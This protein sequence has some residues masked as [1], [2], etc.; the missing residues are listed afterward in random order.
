MKKLLSAFVIIISFLSCS[1]NSDSSQPLYTG[2]S[3]IK[4]NAGGTLFK[5]E[6]N[7]DSVNAGGHGVYAD[8]VTKRPNV[9]INRYRIY[10]NGGAG[11]YVFFTI[12]AEDSLRAGDYELYN[13]LTGAEFPKIIIDNKIYEGFN[14]DGSS[15]ITLHVSR[16]SNGSMDGTFAGTLTWRDP[17]NTNHTETM[18]FTN[19]EFKN[20]AF[21]Y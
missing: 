9:P 21:Q 1:K 19:G 20:V 14:P 3:Y 17:Q 11:N 2:V 5:I 16:H 6:G 13:K 8:K 18:N 4:F 15:K 12:E 10:G 7:L